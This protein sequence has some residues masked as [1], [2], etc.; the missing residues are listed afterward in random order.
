MVGAE[1]P[2]GD[3]HWTAY[4]AC[5]TTA[6]DDLFVVGAAQRDVRALCASCPVRVECLVDALDHGVEFGV[7]GGMTERERRSL[8]RS[9]PEVTSWREVLEAEPEL[10]E[11][12][13]V[14]FPYAPRPSA[15]RSG[16]N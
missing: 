10:L 9:R 13:H 15:G 6:P 14:A 16:S 12:L 5:V 2:D 11:A 4:A 8:R 3:Q 1:R 7:W